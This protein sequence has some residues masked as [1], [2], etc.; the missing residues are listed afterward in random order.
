MLKKINFCFVIINFIGTTEDYPEKCRRSDQTVGVCIIL[1][2]YLF[3]SSI[4]KVSALQSSPHPPKPNKQKQ[5]TSD[6]D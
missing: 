2:G 3:T 6:P 4:F 1:R 5:T